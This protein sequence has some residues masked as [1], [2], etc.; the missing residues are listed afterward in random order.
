MALV[1]KS[2]DFCASFWKCLIRVLVFIYLWPPI[3]H[4]YTHLIVI[5]FIVF[6][7]STFTSSTLILFAGFIFFCK[8]VEQCKDAI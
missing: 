3:L 6:I 7:S 1:Y 4:I 2:S 5:I 8:A